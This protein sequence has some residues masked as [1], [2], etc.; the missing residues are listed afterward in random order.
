MFIVSRP[1]PR[2]T[3]SSSAAAMTAAA[4]FPGS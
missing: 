4:G 2:S 1:Q 3:K